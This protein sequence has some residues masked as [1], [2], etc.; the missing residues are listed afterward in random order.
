MKIK[1]SITFQDKNSYKDFN[2]TLS[3]K[4]VASAE[5]KIVSVEIPYNNTPLSFDFSNIYGKPIYN[6]RTLSYTFSITEKTEKDL[7]DKYREVRNWLL[8][9]GVSELC[10]HDYPD[11]HFEARCNKVS[12]L[13]RIGKT[14]GTIQAEFTANPF[15]IS[16]DFGSIIWD[17]IIFDIDNINLIDYPSANT[18]Q[19]VTYEVYNFSKNSITPKFTVTGTTGLLNCYLNSIQ[20]VFTSDVIDVEVDGFTL[21]S[22]KNI[23][24]LQ[25]VGTLA[26]NM[27]EEVL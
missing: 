24:H 13:T 5:R 7:F 3:S 1:P 9:Q 12:S 27:I 19:G 15:M 11:Y 25:G 20:H 23:L 10:D 2:L 16:I 21:K 14:T 18:A 22:G 26:I 8:S 17:N 6:S 4:D